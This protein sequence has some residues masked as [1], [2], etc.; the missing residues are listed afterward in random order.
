MYT[1]TQTHKRITTTKIVEKH[2]VWENKTEL[3][4]QTHR[5][6]LVN[7]KRNLVAHRKHETV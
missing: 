2:L 6:N 1:K 3:K 5:I 4:P 7:N